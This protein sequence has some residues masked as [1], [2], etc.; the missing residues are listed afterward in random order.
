[1]TDSAAAGETTPA[2]LALIFVVPTLDVD[3]RPFDPAALL[4][5]ATLLFEDAQVTVAVRSCV[6]LSV[7]KPVAVNCCV[8]PL[9]MLGAGGVS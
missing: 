3:A 7:Y 6:E 4:M 1:M 2:R 5:L 8:K 9:A